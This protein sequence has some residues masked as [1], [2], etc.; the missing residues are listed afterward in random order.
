MAEQ[1]TAE[2]KFLDVLS[3]VSVV[4]MI[5]LGIAVLVVV[6]FLKEL[7]LICFALH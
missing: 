7:R 6:E 5:S 1:N 3:T 2:K 4:V